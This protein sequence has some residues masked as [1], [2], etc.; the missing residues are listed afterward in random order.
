MI[1]RVVVHVTKNSELIEVNTK[2]CIKGVVA[3]LDFRN[4][5]NRL[6]RSSAVP[7]LRLKNAL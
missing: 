4:S 6:E 5:L 1:F 2:P 7:A 3:G